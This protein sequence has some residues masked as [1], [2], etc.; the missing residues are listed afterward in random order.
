MSL[1]TRVYFFSLLATVNSELSKCQSVK[2]FL[3]HFDETTFATSTSFANCDTLFDSPDPKLIK[4]YRKLSPEKNHD[5]RDY[6]YVI[7]DHDYD[8]F[9]KTIANLLSEDNLNVHGKYLVVV[10][11]ANL[12]QIAS[13]FR[14][15]WKRDVYNVVVATDD[16]FYTWYPYDSCGDVRVTPANFTH[17]FSD[18]I[19]QKLHCPVRINW[20]RSSINVKDPSDRTDPGIF[21]LYAN[22]LSNVMGAPFEYTEGKTDLT[23]TMLREPEF[24][25]TR[26]MEAEDAAVFIGGFGYF[27][28]QFVDQSLFSTH[29]SS[30]DTVLLLPPRKITPKWREFFKFTPPTAT[31]LICTLFLWGLAIRTSTNKSLVRCFFLSYRIL[32]QMCVPKHPDK[33]HQRVFLF[34]ALVFA[35]LVDSFYLSV[36]SGV[37][38]KPNYEPKIATVEDFASSDTPLRCNPLLTHQVDDDLKNLLLRK[39]TPTYTRG[40]QLLTEFF[41]DADYAV[42]LT[43]LH[44]HYVKNP[45]NVEKIKVRVCVFVS[46]YHSKRTFQMTTSYNAFLVRPRFHLKTKIDAHIREIQEK[47]LGNKFNT[48]SSLYLNQRVVKEK[49]AVRIVDLDDLSG[50]F[51]LLMVGC[52]L[53]VVVFLVEVKQRFVKLT[54][55]SDLSV[56]TIFDANFVNL[57]RH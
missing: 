25:F 1:P 34:S 18:K 13:Y 44:L 52:A 6:D 39:T 24:N 33:P 38:T 10:E 47:G 28:G 21:I 54:V 55:A 4:N 27:Q 22:E 16:S 5:P 51:V 29:V 31:L 19:P 15:L 2:D 3:T 8:D 35:M 40:V 9:T 48:I 14:F 53:S 43:S 41:D 49:D 50:V 17:G 32:I 46:G 20:S 11:A 30:D 42:V 23:R 56:N 36:L 7:V 57:K 37:F 12:S 26:A 45:Q